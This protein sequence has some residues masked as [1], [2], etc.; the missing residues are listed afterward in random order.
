MEG[1]KLLSLPEGE[2]SE[3]R[4]RLGREIAVGVCLWRATISTIFIRS[5]P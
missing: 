4:R 1:I 3:L 5:N 2:A